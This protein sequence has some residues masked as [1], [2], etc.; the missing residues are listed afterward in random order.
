LTEKLPDDPP[1]VAKFIRRLKDLASTRP[2]PQ[3]AA[4]PAAAD[5]GGSS[6]ASS[7]SGGGGGFV[8]G[9]FKD[10]SSVTDAV[11]MAAT[12]LRKA[13]PADPVAYALPR[14]IRWSKVILP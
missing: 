1:D 13:N 8:P 11:M 2:K 12:F 10:E 6:A 4:Q 5:A 7:S 9:E 14:V 3:A